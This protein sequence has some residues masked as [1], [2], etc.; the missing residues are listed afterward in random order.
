[1]RARPF[2]LAYAVSFSAMLCVLPLDW[3]TT[4]FVIDDALYYP[5]VA[6][7]VAGGYGVTYDQLT[8]TNGFHPLWAAVLLPLAVV[9]GGDRTLMLRLTFLAAAAALVLGLVA[10]HRLTRRLGWGPLAAGAIVALLFFPRVDLW[11]SL[12]ESALAL[13]VLLGVLDL[14]DRHRFMISGRR[15]HQ[16]IFGVLLALLFL[17]RLDH[18]FLVASLFVFSVLARVKAGQTP[19]QILRAGATTGGI[20]LALVLPYL[21]ANFHFF[22]HIVP[23]S[24]LA[25]HKDVMSAMT[26][27]RSIF[28]PFAAVSA[29]LGLPVGVLVA[30]AILAFIAAVLWLARQSH[31]PPLPADKLATAFAVGVGLRWLYLRIF[32]P[33]AA[34]TPWYWVPEYALVCLAIGYLV[35]AMAPSLAIRVPALADRLAPWIALV[36]VAALG[37]NYVIKDAH[38]DQAL[39]RVPLEHARWAGDHLPPQTVCAMYDS[40][41]FSYFSGLRTVPL[42]GLIADRRVMEDARDR[43]FNLIM[44][45]LQVDCLVAYLSSQQI[46]A[47]PSRALI[48]RSARQIAGGHFKGEWLAIVDPRI[49]SPYP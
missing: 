22:A 47:V 1:M 42:N 15:A 11:L 24:G 27:V 44:K 14:T 32:V 26:V 16:L 25:K 43:R 46:A 10:A 39:N 9:A 20:A 3:L 31:R 34:E 19:S 12:M 2:L 48:H 17:V 18:V 45:R 21:W 13:A 40:G 33:E 36:T 30:G 29:K 28:W 37:T 7:N 49:H 4:A 8:F 6:L 5:L 23:V 38:R 41:V 35:A